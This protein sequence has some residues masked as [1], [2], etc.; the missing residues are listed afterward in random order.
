M[1]A[2]GKVRRRTRILLTCAIDSL[3]LVAPRTVFW[4]GRVTH[5]WP[6]SP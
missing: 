5:P 6:L 1:E 4:K 2:R 3:E